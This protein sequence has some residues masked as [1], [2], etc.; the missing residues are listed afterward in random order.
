M[1]LR[2]DPGTSENALGPGH[3][4]DG[5][6]DRIQCHA[7]PADV[8]RD[9]ELIAEGNR[10]HD[11]DLAVSGRGL[12]AERARMQ[13]A[14]AGEAFQKDMMIARIVRDQHDAGRAACAIGMKLERGIP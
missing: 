6:A 13:I 7:L 9:A 4:S 14:D 10:L 1:T 11:L 8:R 2:L 12:D 5:E 3:V